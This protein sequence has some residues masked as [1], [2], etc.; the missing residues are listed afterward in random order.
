VARCEA[1]LAE[2]ATPGT[3]AP[4]M[5][6]LTREEWDAMLTPDKQQ[7]IARLHLTI[8][9]LPIKDG[10][11]RNVFTT[12]RVQNASPLP[13]FTAGTYQPIRDFGIE[14]AVET[15]S[16]SP[17]APPSR[18]PHAGDVLPV[19]IHLLAD[20]LGEWGGGPWPLR[21][22]D[23]TKELD[24][25][26]ATRTVLQAHLNSEDD[27]LELLA[28]QAGDQSPRQ[29]ADQPADA[30]QPPTP[31]TTGG[32]LTEAARALG[33]LASPPVPRIDRRAAPAFV[34][35]SRGAEVARTR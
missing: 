33:S 18:S 32:T 24:T 7:T 3:P 13:G 14:V 29:D 17:H 11:P 19:P 5:P 2:L 4:A 6:A 35:A 8:T 23:L 34:R 10:A 21:G 12:D 1:K 9:V 26:A 31:S 28:A 20:P 30:P 16:R 22:I 27:V 15:H 25:L